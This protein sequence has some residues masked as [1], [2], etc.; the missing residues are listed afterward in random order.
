METAEEPQHRDLFLVLFYT[1]G[2][3]TI[4]PRT[5]CNPKQKK[6]FLTSPLRRDFLETLP[7]QLSPSLAK[8]LQT[9]NSEPVTPGHSW[10]SCIT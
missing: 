10:N 5:L 8:P 7:V 3:T 9:A 6:T 4:V 2:I 1:G